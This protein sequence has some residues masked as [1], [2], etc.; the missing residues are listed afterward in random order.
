MN[1]ATNI[2]KI[3]KFR[4]TSIGVGLVFCGLNLILDVVSPWDYRSY[5]IPVIIM[6]YAIAMAF[7]VKSTDDEHKYLWK[8]MLLTISVIFALA[9]T[10]S[11]YAGTT[12]PI[13]IMAL[14]LYREH[15][16]WKDKLESKPPS[17]SDAQA[18]NAT[19]SPEEAK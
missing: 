10:V 14:T 5:A 13:C 1:N 4:L 3:T 2:S 15:Y 11:F 7:S 19:D 9:F 16:F 8:P 18:P 6:I 17:P 12:G